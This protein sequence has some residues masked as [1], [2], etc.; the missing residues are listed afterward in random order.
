M[1]RVLQHRL[2]AVQEAVQVL[3]RVLLHAQT[4]VLSGGLRVLA[5]PVRRVERR[6]GA[7][8][9]AL[10]EGLEREEKGGVGRHVGRPCPRGVQNGRG[11]GRDVE[12]LFHDAVE[13]TGGYQV[14]NAAEARGGGGRVERVIQL[15][16]GVEERKL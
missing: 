6:G 10:E 15:G 14:V 7:A 12:E 2:H 4:Q 3:V 9:D 1:V 16:G 11:E 8:R 13:V 5:N